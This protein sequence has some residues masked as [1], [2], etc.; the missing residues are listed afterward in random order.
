MY[1]L[2]DFIRDCDGNA[3][4]ASPCA[5]KNEVSDRLAPEPLRMF[6][7]RDYLANR[8]R[9]DEG[10]PL[11]AE[12]TQTG[13]ETVQP[14]RTADVYH[15]HL[16][17]LKDAEFELDGHDWTLDRIDEVWEENQERYEEVADSVDLP[18]ELI[19]ALHYRESSFDFD[20][21]MHQ[22]DPLGRPPRRWPTNIPTF[23]EWEDSAEHA[24]DSKGWVRDDLGMTADTTDMA[25]MATYAEYYNGLGYH[26]R[27]RVSPYVY[28]GTDQYEG[29]MY[30]R[31]FQFD[32]K[33]K[34]SRLGVVPVIRHLMES[35]AEDGERE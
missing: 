22:G 25:A 16:D 32:P 17:A 31:D 7:L 35:Q 2:K 34:D 30:V 9:R 19:A 24:L 14:K 6:G 27:D 8:R 12:V 23:H 28:A 20:T 4:G 26:N 11:L 3:D 13:G 18:A 21:Y 5:S 10:T 15:K 29:G 33:A 1:A